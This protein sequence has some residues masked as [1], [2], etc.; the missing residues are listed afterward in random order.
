[1]PGHGLDAEQVGGLDHVGALQRVGEPAALQ[2]VAAVEQQ[3][4]A[5]A[6]FGAQAVG[7]RLEMREA[8]QPAV[9]M[10]RLAEIEIRERMREPRPLG[11]MP[12]CSRNARADQMRRLT[13][14]GADADVDARLAEIALAQLR[15]RIGHM[16]DADVAEAADV[17]NIV[18][19][20]AARCSG[21]TPEA[22]RR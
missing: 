13:R 14:H 9:A 2:D 22:P 11:A 16:Q 8:A 3:R 7:Q 20:R 12:K 10:R 15:V 4:I 5:R 21:T 1:M 18:V 17:V 19:G 6:D